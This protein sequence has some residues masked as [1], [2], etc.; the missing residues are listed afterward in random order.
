MTD[1]PTSSLARI[2]EPL[3]DAY[4]HIIRAQL[5]RLRELEEGARI[6]SDPE[7]IHK[8]RVAVRRLRSA[9]RLLRP[10]HAEK[11][12]LRMRAPVDSLAD[13]LGA[14]RDQDVALEGARVYFATLP[15]ERRRAIDPM[16]WD[17]T[18]RRRRSQRAVLDLLASDDYRQGL[19]RMRDFARREPSGE[20]GRVCDELPAVIWQHYGAVRRFEASPAAA[21][22]QVL[23]RLRIEIK[24]LRYLLEFFEYVLDDRAAGLVKELAGLQGNL[25]A[26]HDAGTLCALVE[27]FVAAQKRRMPSAAGGPLA[28]EAALFRQAIGADILTLRASCVERLQSVSGPA[29]RAVLAKVSGAL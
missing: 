7:F 19:A 27:G 11:R 23:H 25:G 14:V 2:Q 5:E 3:I 6:G 20:S 16:I 4:L 12:I 13:A 1:P 8:L 22:L 29:F 24:R 18:Q 10:Y 17:W 9:L 21:P 15:D 26:L 28:R